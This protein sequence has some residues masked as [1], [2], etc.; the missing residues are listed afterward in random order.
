M[1]APLLI[2]ALVGCLG[3]FAALRPGE[4]TRY[5]LAESQRN[6]LSGNLK[7]VSLT[8]WGIFGVC[9]VVV[10]A[11]AFH[12]KWNVLAPVFRPLFFLVCAGAYLCWG[13]ALLRNPES[14]L[15]RASEPWSR[16]PVWTVRGFGLLLLVGAAGF[17]YGFLAR[18]KVFLQ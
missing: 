13:V 12:S 15:K 3:L 16:L 14:F 6:A 11:I 4:Y 18:I 5:F 10:I 2:F 9:I 8:G 7:A 17:L 1:L